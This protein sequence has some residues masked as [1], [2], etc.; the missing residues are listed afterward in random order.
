[1]QYL[2]EPEYLVITNGKVT[3]AGD[4]YPDMV[5]D[6]SSRGTIII[7]IKDLKQYVGGRWMDI[8]ALVPF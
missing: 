1:M 2:Y 7:R 3:Y 6:D 5:D 8:E 4:F